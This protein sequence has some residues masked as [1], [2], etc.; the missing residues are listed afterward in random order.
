MGTHPIFESDFDCLTECSR[1][2]LSPVTPSAVSSPLSLSS[3]SRIRW[4]CSVPL[5]CV[6]LSWRLSR[7]VSI[8]S[9]STMT[10]DLFQFSAR[11]LKTT[12]L[13][14][15][16]VTRDELSLSISLVRPQ[17]LRESALQASFSGF[18]KTETDTLVSAPRDATLPE[19]PT[20][21]GTSLSTSGTCPRSKSLTPT[22]TPTNIIK[23]CCSLLISV[24]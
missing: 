7:L 5:L 22:L 20:M 13:S 19:T 23:P 12:L 24:Y 4:I 15:P 16:P 14:F 1:S 11:D 8:S 3:L 18:G 17:V 6:R 10:T 9:P 2:E 21:D